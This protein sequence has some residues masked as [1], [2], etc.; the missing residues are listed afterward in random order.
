MA[1]GKMDLG[2]V[3]VHN[4]KQLKMLNSVIFP[5]SYNEKFY[6]DVLT[7]GE[8]A[9]L[10]YYNDLIVGAVCCRIEPMEN[11]DLNQ[12]Y[13]MTLG[14][15]APYRRLKI[16]SHMLLHILKQCELDPSIHSIYLHVQVSNEEALE[17]YAKFGF[18]IV[19][20]RKDYYRKIEPADAYVLR[21]TITPGNFA[22]SQESTAPLYST[23]EVC[24]AH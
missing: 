11:S 23:T 5:V 6:K 13:I 12:V 4:V 22:P 20:T 2:D 19:E 3:T 15:L 17:F 7:M 14:C 24:V 10:A 8:F 16:G 18:H 21:K 9:K 1:V